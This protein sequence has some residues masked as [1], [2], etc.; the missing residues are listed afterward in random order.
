M[1]VVEDNREMNA[2]VAEALR[3][4]HRVATA[5]DGQEGL[6][7]A[8]RLRP[9]LIVSD[10]MMP[11]MS[12]EEL[13]REV[14]RRRDLDDVPI[15]LLSA[16]ADEE[17]RVRLLS[18]GAQ[19]YLVKPFVTEELLARAAG[20]VARKREVEG[21]LRESY[22]LLHAVTEGVSDAIF[23]KDAQS[24]YL[25]INTPGA[26]LLG[27][28]VPEVLGRDDA[29][30]LGPAEGARIRADDAWIIAEGRSLTREE[31]HT[32]DGV[33]RNYLVSKGPHRDKDG[34]VIGVLGIARDV[35]E[36]KRS[37]EE[38][39]KLNAELEQRVHE[40][41]AQLEDANKEME[42][43]SY[44]VSHDLRAP[45]RR[46][47]GFS[48]LLLAQYSDR[49]DAQGQEHLQRLRVSAQRMGQLIDDIL[50]LSRAG[51]A[52]IQR[53]EVDLSA[54]AREIARDL[55]ASQPE[56]PAEFAIA[57]GLVADGDAGLLR[58]VL[59][60]LLG[61]AWKFTGRRPV[62]HIE[63]GAS[64]QAG[65]RVYTVRDDGAGFNPDK[66]GKLFMPFQR[67][68][69]EDDFPGTGIG[70]ALVQRI[71]RRHGGRIWAEGAVDQGA[72][73][74]FTLGETGGPES[75]RGAT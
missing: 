60:N 41:T 59:E 64:E 16:R 15:L 43:F 40:R 39:R 49:L 42:A 62:A 25:M 31:T 57:P 7:K 71:V 34:R 55:R 38:V 36:L 37:E 32:R 61:N 72:A 30:L 75:G 4:G 23:V 50:Q 20:L 3:P 11:R 24:R 69:S 14:R 1:L 21:R 65:E 66:A 73:F 27:R 35:T 2:F 10:I 58:V 70:L 28:A 22:A 53:R 51:R 17:A 6:E 9:D 12:G 18:S 45:L 48:A 68:H 67:L 44:S 47:D 74:H 63:V 56:R 52:E 19:D 8:L 46:I 26:R 54:V 13:V 5:L 33:T 29:A